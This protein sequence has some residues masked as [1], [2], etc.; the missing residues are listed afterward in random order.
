MPGR[1]RESEKESPNALLHAEHEDSATSQAT[2][3][4]MRCRKHQRASEPRRLLGGPPSRQA[5]LAGPWPRILSDP[6]QE[7]APLGAVHG[8][9]GSQP[10]S[11]DLPLVPSPPTNTRPEAWGT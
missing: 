6:F 2:T 4:I 7:P 1:R 9:T 8:C 5:D 10:G 11:L 3:T